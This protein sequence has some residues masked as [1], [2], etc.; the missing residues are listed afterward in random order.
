MIYERGVGRDV[1]FG[2][3]RQFEVQKAMKYA[4]QII[5]QGRKIESAALDQ[6]YE[7]SF[8]HDGYPQAPEKVREHW[9]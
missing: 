5:L 2:Q 1:W 9:T 3:P 8:S 7:G 6:W 4:V